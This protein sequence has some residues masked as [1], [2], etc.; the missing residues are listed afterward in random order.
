MGHLNYFTVALLMTIESSFIPFPSEA[1]IPF[2]AYKAAQGELNIFLVVLSGTAGALAGALVN[3]YLALWLGRPLVYRFARSAIGRM[4]LLSEAKV[5]HAEEYFVKNGK[6]STFIGRLV[7]AVRQLISIPAGLSKMNMR[8]F[9]I[10]TTLGAGIWNVILA[11]T[12]Y[13]LYEVRE[14]IYPWIGEILIFLGVAFV[15][16]LVVKARAGRKRNSKTSQ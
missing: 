15:I 7:P 3:Y 12:G 13:Y 4:L 9:I 10:Y 8:D 2:A 16:Y 1:V 11:V 14:K 5:A 6:S